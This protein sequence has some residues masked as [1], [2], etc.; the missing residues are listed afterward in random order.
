MD[1]WM[2]GCMVA[3]GQ[4]EGIIRAVIGHLSLVIGESVGS[5][6]ISC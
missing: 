1:A 6:I 3:W 5:F 2:H 4:W